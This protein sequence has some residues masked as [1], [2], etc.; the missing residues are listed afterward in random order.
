MKF[1]GQ[2][3][4]FCKVQVP[5]EWQKKGAPGKELVKQQGVGV[6]WKEEGADAH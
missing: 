5:S 4:V 3:P 6:F 2:Q 1:P